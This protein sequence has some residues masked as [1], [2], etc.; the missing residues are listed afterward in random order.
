M[1]HMYR[2]TSGNNHYVM[3]TDAERR[4]LEDD[5]HDG[6]T[7]AVAIPDVTAGGAGS[8]GGL[9]LGVGSGASGGGSIP[10][11]SVAM[12]MR[13][14]GSGSSGDEP[15]DDA[16]DYDGRRGPPSVPNYAFWAKQCARTSSETAVVI[17]PSISSFVLTVPWLIESDFN[18]HQ[19]S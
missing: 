16:G 9:G 6:K 14:S 11:G 17:L 4:R 1:W 5:D 19:S 18:F 8:S 3:A 2:T 7:E 13:G 12:G 10:G 15:M